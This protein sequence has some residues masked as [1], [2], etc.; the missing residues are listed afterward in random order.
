M[1]STL[2]VLLIDPTWVPLVA[3]CIFVNSIVGDKEN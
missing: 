3:S 1:Q 2:K